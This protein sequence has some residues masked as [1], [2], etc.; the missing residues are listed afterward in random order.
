MNII[1]NYPKGVQISS[2]SSSRRNSAS[3]LYNIPALLHIYLC[4]HGLSY[5]GKYEWKC[6]NL[7][8]FVVSTLFMIL[9]EI[10]KMYGT[11]RFFVHLNYSNLSRISYI[12]GTVN[13]L[14]CLLRILF[15]LKKNKFNHIINRMLKI[16]CATSNKK[17]PKYSV[18]LIFVFIVNDIYTIYTFY[19]IYI[20]LNSVAFTKHY[21]NYTSNEYKTFITKPLN[22]ALLFM[23]VWGVITPFIPIYFCCFCLIF[24]ETL[25]N[26]KY[27][28][29][30]ACN[31][32]FNM[33]DQMC[34]EIIKL[35]SDINE[36]FHTILLVN[37]IILFVSILNNVYII[38]LYNSMTGNDLAY[39]IWNTLIIFTRFALICLFAS[40]TS[41]AGIELK[42]SIYNHVTQTRERWKCFIL[43][44]KISESFVEL[45]FLDSLVLDK[46]LIVASVGSIVTYV[47]IIATFNINSKL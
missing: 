32:G 24:K 27:K 47:I 16:Y 22:I 25:N 33:L 38:L 28:L 19:G 13:F 23:E 7:T 44:T 29:E 42:R 15:C 20:S 30:K 12:L 37:F 6:K 26:F 5:A 35:T 34:E 2:D 3:S 41:K 46:N 36:S 14:E 9:N 31:I 45:K 39:R 40:S 17:I 11:L 18:Y 21:S 8:L 1:R 43:V 10:N 4:S